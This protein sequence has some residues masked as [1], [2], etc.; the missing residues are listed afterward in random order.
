[1]L[2]YHPFVGLGFDFSP[3]MNSNFGIFSPSTTFS[4]GLGAQGVEV[5]LAP[6]GVIIWH[7]EKLGTRLDNC[8]SII[9]LSLFPKLAIGMFY[10]AL[11]EMLLLPAGR[12]I[13]KR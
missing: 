2:L 9:F 5:N 7:V 3:S 1:M 4:M 13:I 10:R 6:D 11:L 8:W 12:R